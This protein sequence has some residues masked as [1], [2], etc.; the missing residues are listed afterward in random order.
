M[1]T[2]AG[3]IKFFIEE[4]INH[5]NLLVIDQLIAP[6]IDFHAL[7]TRPLTTRQAIKDNYLKLHQ[8]FP[9]IHAIIQTSII[10]QQHVVAHQTWLGTQQKMFLGVPASHRH[11]SLTVLSFFKL[12]DQQITEVHQA[13]NWPQHSSALP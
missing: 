7:W 6:S 4:V 11:V 9:D 10:E 1:V 8:T 2:S 3:I 13:I 12:Q 5:K